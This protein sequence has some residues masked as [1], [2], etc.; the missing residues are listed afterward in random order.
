[1][2]AE[3][4]ESKLKWLLR[5]YCLVEKSK[6]EEEYHEAKFTCGNVDPCSETFATS[7]AQKSVLER[8]FPDLKPYINPEEAS[9]KSNVA[10]SS[11]NVATSTPNIA[12][13]AARLRL[14]V[15][16]KIAAVIAPAW[17]DTPGAGSLIA[18]CRELARVSDTLARALITECSKETEGDDA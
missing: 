7:L 5:R 4:M 1:M 2:F 6:V 3:D 16:A 8:L 18:K 12:T 15:A 13:S 11:H 10:T 17:A 9:T 14:R